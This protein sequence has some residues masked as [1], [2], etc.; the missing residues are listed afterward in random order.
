M[1]RLSNGVSIGADWTIEGSGPV[2][3]AVM[4]GVAEIRNGRVLRMPAAVV[5]APDGEPVPSRLTGTRRVTTRAA[6]T[7]WLAALGGA[8]GVTVIEC[9]EDGPLP[10]VVAPKPRGVHRQNPPRHSRR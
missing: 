9:P 7:D 6:F 5:V 4:L 10:R 1:W 2:A 8:V 3:R